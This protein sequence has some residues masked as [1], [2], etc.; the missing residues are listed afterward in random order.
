MCENNESVSSDEGGG[1][2]KSRGEEPGGIAGN[3]IYRESVCVC[4]R[5]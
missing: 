1:V 5:V 2:T 3:S 4:E